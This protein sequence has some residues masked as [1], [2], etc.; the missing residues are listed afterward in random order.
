[1]LLEVNM[2]TLEGKLTVL[3]AVVN[4]MRAMCAM[5]AILPAITWGVGQEVVVKD[6]RKTISRVVNM[7]G[8]FAYL[9]GRFQLFA[10]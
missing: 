1:M 2:S 8:E 10:L 5:S 6:G 7:G 4:I 3:V 9:L